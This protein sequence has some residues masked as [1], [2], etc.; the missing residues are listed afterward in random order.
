MS[1]QYR[2]FCVPVTC[3]EEVESEL[4]DFLKTVQVIT[5]HRDMI[6]QEARFYWAIAVEYATG[7]TR[8]AR[9]GEPGKKKIDYKEVLSP[10]EE[11]RDRRNLL[12]LKRQIAIDCE[13][14]RERRNTDGD[15][16]PLFFY[17]WS[18]CSSTPVPHLQR[19]GMIKEG[20]FPPILRVPYQVV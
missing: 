17:R 20:L 8:D 15:S 9:G 12:H 16:N 5:L 1:L 7:R 4:N 3:A 13:T 2:F 10:E 11:D 14:G 18:L 19:S 6:C